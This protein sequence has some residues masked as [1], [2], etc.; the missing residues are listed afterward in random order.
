MNIQLQAQLITSLKNNLTN[1]YSS[2]NKE[3]R[4]ILHK[5]AFRGDVEY[6]HEGS[7]RKKKSSDTR[8]NDSVIYRIAGPFNL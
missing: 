2:M 1:P 4:E 7:W 6:L 8:F 3:G 5:A